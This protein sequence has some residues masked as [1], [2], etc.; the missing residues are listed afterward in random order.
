[1][2]AP[3]ARLLNIWE[4]WAEEQTSVSFVVKRIRHPREEAKE[5]VEASGH[6]LEE[7]RQSVRETEAGQVVRRRV[8]RRSSS[9]SRRARGPDTVHPKVGQ[10]TRDEL[11]A[12]IKAKMQMMM[13]QKETIEKELAKLQLLEQDQEREREESLP[14]VEQR[15]MKELPDMSQ[16]SGVESGMVTDDSEARTRP[17]L[18]ASRDYCSMEG[19]L[20]AGQEVD[21]EVELQPPPENLELW[22]SSMERMEKLNRRLM[23]VEEEIVA[24]SYEYS[25]LAQDKVRVASPIECFN[26]EV[27]KYRKINANLLREITENRGKI[28]H[29]DEEHKKAKKMVSRVEFDLNLVER[30][31]KRLE[32]GLEKVKVREKGLEEVQELDEEVEHEREQQVQELE[33]DFECLDNEEEGILTDFGLFDPDC[34]EVSVLHSSTLV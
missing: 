15:M 11:R 29:T 26:T 28:K 10:R 30:Q 8:S 3:S 32:E 12:G 13:A 2:L 19:G 18:G 24:L 14:V 21:Q 27:A 6:S 1:M 23:E 22:L 31:A 17:P 16:D 20:K 9:V 4:A 34:T 7:M 25:T 33:V 5:V